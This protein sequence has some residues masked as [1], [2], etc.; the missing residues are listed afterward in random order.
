MFLRMHQKWV[1]SRAVAA[2]FGE[3]FPFVPVLQPGRIVVVF[4]LERACDGIMR[5]DSTPDHCL[6]P[7]RPV[8]QLRLIQVAHSKDHWVHQIGSKREL[9]EWLPKSERQEFINESA[10]RCNSQQN[11]SCDP[12]NARQPTEGLVSR[13]FRRGP[14]LTLLRHRIIVVVVDVDDE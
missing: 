10:V 1:A 4:P 8:I 5:G 13:K 9:S 11:Y 3:A 14:V 12:E 7:S 6:V 2:R